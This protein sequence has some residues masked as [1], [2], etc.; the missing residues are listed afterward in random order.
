MI[1]YSIRTAFT[2]VLFITTSERLKSFEVDSSRHTAVKSSQVESDV[3]KS[4]A[5]DCLWAGKLS[6]YVTSHLGQ[7]SLPSLRGR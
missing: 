6:Q 4:T 7:L 3:L 1:S 5:V 2:Q